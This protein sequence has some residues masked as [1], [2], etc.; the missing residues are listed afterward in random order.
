MDTAE[1]IKE[2]IQRLRND[3]YRRS[4]AQT[5][6]GNIFLQRGAFSTEEDFNAEL[7]ELIRK[8]ESGECYEF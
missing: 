1:E 2:R 4:V 3:A 7:N 6:H 5:A 8:W